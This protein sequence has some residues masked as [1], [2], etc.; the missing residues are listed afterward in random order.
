MIACQDKW[1]PSALAQ[2]HIHLRLAAGRAYREAGGGRGAWRG[3]VW[4]TEV[5]GWWLCCSRCNS[6]HTNGG[7]LSIYIDSK[8]SS[9]RCS[10]HFS[11][12]GDF[13][14]WFPW[15]QKE[16]V[17][18]ELRSYL[19]RPGRRVVMKERP[20]VDLKVRLTLM[21]SPRWSMSALTEPEAY[22]HTHTRQ[23]AQTR[24]GPLLRAGG[25]ASADRSFTRQLLQESLISVWAEPVCRLAP[26]H[27]PP[28]PPSMA[29]H[30][31]G[32]HSS[33]TIR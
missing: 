4:F 16:L 17:S 25:C 11:N 7:V 28:P 5:D 9:L 14:P 22:T 1:H 8:L 32:E 18:P 15:L 10:A 23:P 6:C 19:S 13:A 26:P 24:P 2:L 29:Q 21:P 30:S 33:E 31:Q 12:A 20:G 27:T 3:L